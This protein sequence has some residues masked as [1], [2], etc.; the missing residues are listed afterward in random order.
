MYEWFQVFLFFGVFGVKDSTMHVAIMQPYFFP[1]LG[2]F[3]LINAVEMFVVY[4]NIQFTKKSFIKRNR[5]LQNGKPAVFT[6]PIKKDSCFLDIEERVVCE[7]F[8]RRKLLNQIK[9]AYQKAPYFEQVYDLFRKAVLYEQENLFRFIHHSICEVCNY[10]GIETEFIISS[11]I[12]IDHALKSQEKVIAIC[13]ELST[14]TYINP[15]GGMHLYDKEAFL[16]EGIV[17][18]F[19]RMKDIQYGQ[20]GCP[21]V[22]SLS[23]LDVM[24]F[25]SRSE[26][27]RLLGEYELV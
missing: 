19:L 9:D 17:L 24:M 1:Y 12:S 7:T 3:Q 8:N 2:Y 4:D 15:I 16:K 27:R 13:R 25:N 18:K 14:D 5:F 26:I 10:L 20:F 23:V 22:P 11:T 21:F 6:I